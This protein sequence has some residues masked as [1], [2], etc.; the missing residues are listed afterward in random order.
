VVA[1]EVDSIIEKYLKT[2]FIRRSQ[3][4]YAA[5][6]VVVLKKN[7]GIRITCDYR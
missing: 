3:S 5:P 6:I 4:P 1:S 2:G 7:G